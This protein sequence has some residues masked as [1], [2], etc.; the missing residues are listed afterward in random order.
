MSQEVILNGRTSNIAPD[1]ALVVNR[2]ARF[3]PPIL[4]GLMPT[5]IAINGLARPPVLNG[6]VL[7]LPLYHSALSN[8]GSV[9]SLDANQYLGTVTGALWRPNGRHFDGSD[10]VINFGDF[11]H[12]EQCTVIAWINTETYTNY[13]GLFCQDLTDHRGVQLF[14]HS[15]DSK[16]R[17]AIYNGTTFRN[18]E[19]NQASATMVAG[20]WYCVA[21]TA[22]AVGTDKIKAYIDAVEVASANTVGLIG[23]STADFLIGNDEKGANRFYDG[24][25]G[26]VWFYNR[27]LTANELLQTYLATKWRY[28]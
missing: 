26:E 5:D 11:V 16:L 17:F 20:T 23:N 21:G 27:P 12:V 18:G 14:L 15:V 6:C 3:E 7:Y 19:A 4:N 8:P 10:D 25:I 9:K 1:N 13:Q 24:L 28:K 22:G 2:A